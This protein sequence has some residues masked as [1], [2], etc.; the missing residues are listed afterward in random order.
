ME[1]E[2]LPAG[3]DIEKDHFISISHL[4]ITFSLFYQICNFVY[5]EGITIER[6]F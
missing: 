4:K 5:D 3:Y 6:S 2:V 1:N